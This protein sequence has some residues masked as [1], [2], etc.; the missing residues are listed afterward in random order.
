MKKILTMTCLAFYLFAGA[1]SGRAAPKMQKTVE[2]NSGTSGNAPV[3]DGTIAAEEWREARRESFSDGSEFILLR[4]EDEL[5]LGIRAKPKERIAAN[6]FIDT[7]GDITIYHAS[8]AIGTAVYRKDGDIF[9]L[10]RNFAWRC[11]GSGDGEKHRAEREAF[12]HEEGWIASTSWMG[13]PHEIE[14]RIRTAPAAI[15]LAVVFMKATEPNRK[16]PWPAELDDDCLEPT[17]GG[18]PPVLSFLPET[19]A[20]ITEFKS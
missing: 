18:L 13:S 10:V 9:R 19:W 14:Y 17:P 3:I 20:T 11:R 15:R 7:G 2:V 6:V 16:I 5:Y 4:K 8:A 12:L 1:W